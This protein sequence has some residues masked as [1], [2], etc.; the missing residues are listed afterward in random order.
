MFFI[1][2]LKYI[3]LILI[4]QTTTT[5]IFSID[6]S[7]SI[8]VVNI[9]YMNDNSGDLMFTNE[10]GTEE[11]YSYEVVL[12][13]E[14]PIGWTVL[15][16][17]GDSVEL[18]LQPNGSIIRIAENT[19][20]KVMSLQGIDDSESSDFELL[21]GKFRTIASKLIGDE[22]YN[23]YGQIS[24]CGVRGTDFGM[25]I[26]ADD[27]YGIKEETFVFEG[28][29]ELTHLKTGE[30]IFLTDNQY[31][32]AMD[33]DFRA[34]NMSTAVQSTFQEELDFKEVKPE[35]IQTEV[36]DVSFI[37]PGD[38][39]T[40]DTA[41]ETT[42]MVFETPIL[43]TS[44]INIGLIENTIGTGGNFTNIGPKMQPEGEEEEPK[45]EFL[46][47]LIAFEVGTI[48]LDDQIYGKAV[49]TPN[50]II[51]KFHL[52]LYLPVIYYNNILE[53]G[54]WYRPK[55][56]NEWSFGTDQDG[57]PDVLRDI[58][59]DFILKIR[60]I[61][62]G[63]QRDKFHFQ[64]GNLSSITLGHGFIMRGF[65]NDSDFPAIRRVGLDLG[66]NIPVF[67]MQAM[68]GDLSEPEIIGARFQIKAGPVGIGI[69]G[70]ADLD[71]AG[72]IPESESYNEEALGDPMIF[73]FGL[74]V[75]IPIV[76][77]D[78]LRLVY[79]ADIAA[80]IPYFREDSSYFS[81]IEAGFK[82]RSFINRD[83]DFSFRNVGFGTGIIGETGPI[84]FRAEYRLYNGVFEPNLI[85]NM[86]ERDRGNFAL[87]MADYI[88]DP[89]DPKW[90]IFYMSIYG[91]LRYTRESIFYVEGAYNLPMSIS[92]ADGFNFE[93]KD[94]LHFEAGMLPTALPINLGIS[95][96][97][98]RNYFVTWM[99]DQE[100][101]DGEALS[102]FDAFSLFR[103]T[104]IYGPTDNVDLLFIFTTTADRNSDGSV[105]YNSDG[106]AEMVTT[107][108]LETRVH[109]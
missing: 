37:E 104:T 56:N 31:A 51:G 44:S 7:A 63:E 107:F 68:V 50:F 54:N 5:L 61:K 34:I 105:I 28:K 100:T 9:M 47:N 94:Y 21:F 30:M 39:P 58:L 77:K 73:A 99:V 80:L 20:F 24:A 60:F 86:Y 29:V 15:T 76:D 27:F 64:A 32:N 35:D 66:F 74:D 78:N 67:G 101:D 14:L 41:A 16:G 46:S 10:T 22:A 81:N 89:S 62:F 49:F 96:T 57:T 8:P 83:P 75:D 55:G 102:F 108:S 88:N 71:P 13:S 25:Q 11:L 109:F 95:L 3:V 53:A 4:L 17:N 42:P 48:I 43:P 1:K 84:D 70:I 98:A 103:F 65:A 36:P 18:Q 19:N 26:I 72:D 87:R 52:S 85:N 59:R 2:K 90:D 6:N 38:D 33:P 93:E 12:G 23:F 40:D 92:S 106:T 91:E 82:I 97:Y 45:N 69:S 79:F